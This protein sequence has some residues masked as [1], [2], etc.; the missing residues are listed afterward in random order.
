MCPDDRLVVLIPEQR[1]DGGI[2]GRAD[3]GPDIVRGHGAPPGDGV[4]IPHDIRAAVPVQ[5]VVMHRGRGHAGKILQAARLGTLIVAVVGN[6]ARQIQ[7]TAVFNKGFDFVVNRV[8]G[9]VGSRVEDSLD[10]AGNGGTALQ[11]PLAQGG[12]RAH[13]GRLQD[14]DAADAGRVACIPIG[15]AAQPG[16]VG[17]EDRYL[18]CFVLRFHLPG[19]QIVIAHPIELLPGHV[20][21]G[22]AQPPREEGLGAVL[23]APVLHVA[24]THGKAHVHIAEEAV[25][26][27]THRRRGNRVVAQIGEKRMGPFSEFADTEGLADGPHVGVLHI[28]REGILHLEV[29]DIGIGQVAER[30]R[31]VKALLRPAVEFAQDRVLAG[32]FRL[33]LIDQGTGPGFD[34]IGPELVVILRLPVSPE[35]V[36]RSVGID[37]GIRIIFIDRHGSKRAVAG[38]PC[39]VQRSNAAVAGRQEIM[40]GCQVGIA[41]SGDHIAIEVID[42]AGHVLVTGGEFPGALLGQLVCGRVLRHVVANGDPHHVDLAIFLRQI[43]RIVYLAVIFFCFLR[44]G[45]D[46][47]PW[48]VNRIL[49]QVFIDMEA[50][51][52]P[53][54]KILL[55]LQPGL[56]LI[57]K[58]VGAVVRARGENC[59][60]TA[61]RLLDPDIIVVVDEIH[62]VLNDV[63]FPDRE[64]VAELVDGGPRLILERHLNPVKIIGEGGIRP[65]HRQGLQGARRHLIRQVLAFDQRA[66]AVLI[67]PDLRG[68]RHRVPSAVRDLDL[69]LGTF[70]G[71]VVVPFILHVL[72]IHI[73]NQGTGQL[74]QA[75]AQG[76][77]AACEQILVG[78]AEESDAGPGIFLPF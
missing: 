56:A 63:L 21:A 30:R 11:R 6:I 54:L 60:I 49:L 16:V 57:D 62:A 50:G 59:L 28:L 73:L 41:E 66:G 9:I 2:E 25:P 58:Q 5:A 78:H 18:G 53:L 72:E 64:T 19:E 68:A 45:K 3:I 67:D 24:G 13:V 70:A 31:R 20:V 38:T 46:P 52:L 61:V 65:I 29:S 48:L 15:G 34:Q 55:P 44:I 26:R 42:Q 47:N 12:D 71:A 14:I 27:V 35:P 23:P 77:I 37:A 22:I 51:V 36:T 75:R 4:I 1:G 69:H 8:A 74:F 10:A 39:A 43:D 17:Q 7:H 40:P 76:G 33:D 32:I